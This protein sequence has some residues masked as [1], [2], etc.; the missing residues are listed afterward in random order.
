MELLWSVLSNEVVQILHRV[1]G[2]AYEAAM[3]AVYCTCLSVARRWVDTA[4]GHRRWVVQETTGEG[5]EPIIF[6][7]NAGLGLA[8][9]TTATV[10]I[11]CVLVLAGFCLRTCSTTV[12][13]RLREEAVESNN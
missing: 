6:T 1:A 5:G 13:R 3:N 4:F 10:G 2:D 8:A 9:A 7:D 12:R 11:T